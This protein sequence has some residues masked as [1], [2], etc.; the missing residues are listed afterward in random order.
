MLY[1]EFTDLIG[2][3]EALEAGRSA[4]EALPEKCYFLDRD[5]VLRGYQYLLQ[6]HQ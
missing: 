4:A 6:Q 5:T 1:N 3:I 2:Q